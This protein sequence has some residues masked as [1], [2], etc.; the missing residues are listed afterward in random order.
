[1]SHE[2]AIALLEINAEAAENNA[3]ILEAEGD[4][5]QAKECRQAAVNYREAIA[6]LSE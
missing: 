3:G 1:M 6:A 4:T 2:Y 5:E